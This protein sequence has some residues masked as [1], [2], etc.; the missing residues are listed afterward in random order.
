VVKSHE[1][2]S[3]TDFSD[4][5]SRRMGFIPIPIT[6]MLIRVI[7]QSIDFS[8]NVY[9]V[10]FGKFSINYLYFLIAL[11]WLLL[12]TIKI[13]NGVFL[14]G[15]AVDYVARYRLLQQQAENNLYRKR[16]LSAK[17]K[18]APNSPRLSLIDFTG[19]LSTKFNAI[20]YF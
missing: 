16:M 14:H 4:Q 15:N 20:L 17:S 1:K 13:V 10:V 6:I 11:L 2:D 5:V 18:S 19:I 7:G 9:I 12:C 8:R 3:L